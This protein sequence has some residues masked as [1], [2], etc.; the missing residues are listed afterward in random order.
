MADAQRIL[1]RG[2]QVVT[3]NDVLVAD[4]LIEGEQILGILTPESDSTAERVIDA[5][6]CYVFPGIVDAHT[7]IML[8]TGLYQT[9]DS[10]EIGTRA[11]AFGGV[12]T[13]I[14]LVVNAAIAS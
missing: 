2:G 6:G 11:A 7:H 4:V 14:D 13:V 12:T 5:A 10:W 9:V 8:D 3:G 1:I